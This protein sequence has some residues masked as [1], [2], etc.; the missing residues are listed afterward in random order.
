MA[1]DN[2]EKSG[3]MVKIAE[4]TAPGDSPVTSSDFVKVTESA[5]EMVGN[6]DPLLVIALALV[7]VAKGASVI[8]LR[9]VVVDN[10]PED[11]QQY[12]TQIRRMRDAVDM[13]LT[14]AQELASGV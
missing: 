13:A 4:Q 7:P 1:K 11:R 5:V 12:V 8:E 9:K 10:V 2:K 14:L 3:E 6:M